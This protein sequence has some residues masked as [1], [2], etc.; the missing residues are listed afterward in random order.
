VLWPPNVAPLKLSQLET[1]M[2]SLKSCPICREPNAAVFLSIASPVNCSTLFPSRSEATSARKGTIALAFCKCCGMIFNA[3]Y[4][5]ALLEYDGDYDNSLHF[6]PAFQAYCEALIRR[7]TDSYNLRNKVI[8]EVGCGNGEFLTQ[9][10]E[11]GNNRGFGFDPAF[12]GISP[13]PSVRISPQMY[14][15][16]N[17]DVKA[18]AVCCRHVLEHIPDPCAFLQGIAGNLDDSPGSVFYCETP[19]AAAVLT[20]GSLWDVIYPH[21]SYF[22]PVS[23]TQALRRAGFKVLHVGTSFENQFL[24]VEAIRDQSLSETPDLST[25]EELTALAGFVNLFADRFSLAMERWGALIENSV[26]ENRK[27]ALWGAGAK[28]VTFLNMVP[29]AGQI[30]AIVDSNPRKHGMFVPGTGQQICSP[31]NLVDYRP[32][33]VILLNDAYEAEVRHAL[34]TLAPEASLWVS[35]S[36]FPSTGVEQ[37]AA[38]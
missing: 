8:V 5:A 24:A 19:N 15:S 38:A 22:T 30:G 26:R 10:C 4:E 2:T 34:G 7:L 25:A 37:L 36:G 29:H 33:A 35:N 6:S 14:S 31:A 13:S 18:D 12:T 20:G 28:A 32:H 16:A 9:L 3:A 11:S 21:C 27:I 23:I 17:M 1:D